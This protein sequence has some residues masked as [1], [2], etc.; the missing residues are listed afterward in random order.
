MRSAKTLGLRTVAV[1]SD[2]DRDALH[3]RSADQA[4]RIGPAPA[5]DSYLNI[6]AI[7]EAAKMSG[8]QAIHPG[9]G[10]L[11]ENADFAEACLDAG[12]IFVGPAAESIRSMGSKIEAKRRVSAAG[13]PVVPG[14]HGDAQD[15]ATLAAQA[16][17][18]G[19]PL[20]IKAS[21]GGGGKGMRIV[22]EQADFAAA[23]ESARR[24]ALAAFADDQVL[25]E[26]YLGAPKHIEVQILADNHGNTL[27]LFERDCSV[28]RR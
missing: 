10:F 24:E 8:A 25:L 6:P 22:T 17:E 5:K 13:T 1:Y 19:F 28:Q 16:L 2:A 23:L 3:V 4:V 15:D 18:V 20:L 11:S 21:A 12:L 7:I 26:R 14:Y 27:H 9:Y